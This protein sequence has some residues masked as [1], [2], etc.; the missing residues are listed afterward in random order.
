[1]KHPWRTLLVAFGLVAAGLY[2]LAL[3]ALADLDRI[4]AAGAVETSADDPLPGWKSWPL[5]LVSQLLPLRQ[6]G[7]STV[8]PG[9]TVRDCPDCPE[10]VTIPAGYYLIGSPLI[11][12]GRH[13]HFF[14]RYPV[15]AQFRFLNRE[16]PRRLVHIRHAFAL[17]KYEVTFADW[18]RAQADPEWEKITGR[19]AR[20]IAFGEA[21]Y[22]TRPVTQ[23]DQDDAHA[24]AAWLSAKTGRTYRLPSEA[25]WEYAARAGTATPY[26]WGNRME[27]GRAACFGCGGAW[28]QWRVGP[29]GLEPPNGFGLYD[30]A[31]NGWEW[32]EDCFTPSH[33][34]A[35]I[36]GSAYKGGDCELAVFKGG[37]TFSPDWQVRSAMRVG[38]HPY[39][40]GEGSTIRLLRELP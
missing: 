16:G 4:V 15:R 24:Y 7:A 37:S 32:T 36:D 27:P 11:E 19:P 31:G 21:D 26:Y 3:W 35:I 33:P 12:Y 28:D 29:V 13:Q 23:V 2:G 39:N 17:S 6:P 18:E 5:F 10:M 40:N 22:L 20:M 34:A 9:E 38:P 8:M 30:M 14:G 1:M 25:E